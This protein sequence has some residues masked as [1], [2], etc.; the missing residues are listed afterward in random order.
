MVTQEILQPPVH[1]HATKLLIN[2]EWVNSLSAQTFAT[3]NPSTG[4][5][6]SDVAAAGADDVDRAVQAARTAFDA[7]DWPQMPAR[8]RG[9]LLYKLAD[10]IE[11][12]ADELA[13]LETLD[14][15]KPLKES[16]HID[17]P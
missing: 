12:H 9:Q 10:L 6:I 11:T 17:L 14:N 15:G 7:G 4:E 2:S 13:R 3:L 5:V 8:D 1:V 16:R